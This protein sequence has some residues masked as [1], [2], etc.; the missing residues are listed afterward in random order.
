MSLLIALLAGVGIALL[1]AFV[2][3]VGGMLSMSAVAMGSVVTTLL[4]V[5]LLQLKP[6][7]SEIRFMRRLVEARGHL[8]AEESQHLAAL[9]KGPVGDELKQV[10]DTVQ[11]FY[12][13]SIGVVGRSGKIA[14]AGAEVSYAADVLKG[15]I[16]DQIEHLQKITDATGSIS[17]NIEQAVNNS[18]TLKELSRQ[19]RRA[20]YIGQEAI[21]E[22]AEQMRNTGNH[23]QQAAELIAKLEDR[24]GQISQITKVISEIADQTNLLA[25]N[26]AIE[27]ARA[28]EQGRGFAVVA[29]EVRNLATRT[30]SATT[31]IGQMVQRINEETGNAGNTMRSL[32]SEV[33]ESRTRTEKVDTQLIEI[34]EHAREVESR[35]ISAAE[36]SEQNREHQGQ[37]NQSLEV[38]SQSLN[39]S[40]EKVE[41]V[42]SQSLELSEMAES[43]YELLGDT[44][45][46][47][48]HGVAYEEG[49]AA[50][51]AIQQVFEQAIASGKLSLDQVFDRDYKPI[52]GSNPQKYK[53][54]FDDFTDAN[55]PA[56]QEPILTR[57]EFMAYAG[58][59]D[60]NGYF[61]THNKRYSQPITG[62]YDKDL[63]TNRTKRI[64]NDRTGA[65][66]GISTKPFL[67]QTYKRDTGEVMHDLCIP[68]Y[69][70]GRHWGGF[71][72]GYQSSDE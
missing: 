44:G 22:A 59:V 25:L 46:Q 70:A 7:L 65:R 13:C 62:D 27:A 54:Q 6:I 66:C 58:A 38:F 60:N 51:D 23:A 29:E 52:P 30:S 12:S 71:R 43:I 32:V 4:L 1:V 53:T 9:G 45:L 14:I 69:V 72:I 68:I 31:E 64:F 48:E 3:P 63:L 10:G 19:T 26:A 21:G 57:H 55:L 50:V 41:S 39:S 8:E 35:V 40:S 67:L 16:D 36:R 2:A 18:D 61:P 20:S 34:L 47:G 28:G 33:E 37:I 49:R 15:R 24:A 5:Y 56:I 11:Q 42:A 17:S